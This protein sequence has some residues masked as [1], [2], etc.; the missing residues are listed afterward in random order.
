LRITVVFLTGAGV[1]LAWV[2]DRSA[3][4]VGNAYPM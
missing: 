1:V 3:L 4:H 2:I